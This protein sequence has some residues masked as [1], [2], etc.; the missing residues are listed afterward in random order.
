MIAV[1]DEVEIKIDEFRHYQD[2]WSLD[3]ITPPFV[4][5]NA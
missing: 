2:F 3:K 1:K 4:L 5:E